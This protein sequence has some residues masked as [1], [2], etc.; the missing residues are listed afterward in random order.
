MGILITA[1]TAALLYTAFLLLFG[2]DALGTNKPFLNQILDF[3]IHSTPSLF[4]AAITLIPWRK[5]FISGALWLSASVIFT[6]FFNALQSA[7]TIML[8][9]AAP[10]AVSFLSFYPDKKNIR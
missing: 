7:V 5:P 10:L 2:F 8:L 3:L 1:R 9:T 6:I 4:L